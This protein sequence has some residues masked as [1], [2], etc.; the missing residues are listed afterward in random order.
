MRKKFCV[1]TKDG[2]L[3]N[4][5]EI[6]FFQRNSDELQLDQESFYRKYS[7]KI[8]DKN[9]EMRLD[10]SAPFTFPTLVDSKIH[11]HL[12]KDMEWYICYPPKINSMEEAITLAKNWA[13]LTIFHLKYN[14]DPNILEAFGSWILEKVGTGKKELSPFLEIPLWIEHEWPKWRI[15]II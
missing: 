15:E 12:G 8:P 5:F 6:S 7:G 2:E 9:V 1:Y 4:E 14:V 10:E 13:I 11:I 3:L